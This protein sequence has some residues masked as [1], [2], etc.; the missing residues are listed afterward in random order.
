M[1]VEG[2]VAGAAV[3]ETAR[4]ASRGLRL[5]IVDIWLDEAEGCVGGSI[6]NLM[7]FLEPL[8]EA[9]TDTDLQV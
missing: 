5:H 1:S 4:S 7:R 6:E 9:M 2:L 3:A 8:S